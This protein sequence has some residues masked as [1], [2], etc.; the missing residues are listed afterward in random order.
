MT[1]DATAIAQFAPLI[2]AGIA[3]TVA[4]TTVIYQRTQERLAVNRAILAEV[5]RLLAVIKR[6]REWW[7]SCLA[8]GDSSLPLIEFSTTVYDKLT[9]RLGQVHPA[10]IAAVVSFYGYVKFINALQKRAS[11]MTRPDR[12]I[13]SLPSTRKRFVRRSSTNQP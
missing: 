8:C 6:H 9:D 13:R 4:L 12:R 5:S 11:S 10:H 2:A 1:L 7:E 3:A